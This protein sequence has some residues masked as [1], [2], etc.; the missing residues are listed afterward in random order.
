MKVIIDGVE[1]VPLKKKLL[2]DHNFRVSSVGWE[3]IIV[4]S[5]EYLVNPEEDIWEINEGEFKGEQL[6]TWDSAMRETK[7]AGKEMPTIDELCGEEIDNVK[8]VGRRYTSGTFGNRGSYVDLWSS[9]FSGSLAWR[10][11]LNSKSASVIRYPDSQ[12]YGFS[13]RVKI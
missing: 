3:K 2:E 7:K 13:V 1:Y 11:Y 6:F 5:K 4:D 8:Y 9:S 12:A 10:R